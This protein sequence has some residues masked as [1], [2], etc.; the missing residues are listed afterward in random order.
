MRGADFPRGLK[1]RRVRN[2]GHFVHQEQPEEVN[3]LVIEWL[4]KHER[5]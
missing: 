2:A 1:V 5:A 3:A 4:K